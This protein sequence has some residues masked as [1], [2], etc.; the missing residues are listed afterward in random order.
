M[1]T[2]ADDYT[3]P[4]EELVGVNRGCT[5]QRLGNI[6]CGAPLREQL[7]HARPDGVRKAPPALRR[8]WV[9]CVLQTV[10]E[11][12]DLYRFVMNGCRE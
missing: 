9:L 5:R 8:G 7:R 3:R 10:E 11:N 4:I 6:H 12:R 2:T 1:A